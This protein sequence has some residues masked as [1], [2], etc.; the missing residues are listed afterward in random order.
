MT[1][2]TCLLAGHDYAGWDWID[3]LEKGTIVKVTTGPCAGRY[4]V[5]GHRW[6]ARKGGPIP[7]WMSRTDLVLQT[8]TGASGTGFS[9]ARRL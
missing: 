2:P 9:L 1:S 3:D 7:S 4:R 6:Q 8:C 5:T